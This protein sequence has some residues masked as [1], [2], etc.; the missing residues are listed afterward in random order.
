MKH[1]SKW[2]ELVWWRRNILVSDKYQSTALLNSNKEGV[3]RSNRVA[4][5]LWS[6][7]S[8]FRFLGDKQ[9]SNAQI[10]FRSANLTKNHRKAIEAQLKNRW[11]NKWWNTFASNFTGNYYKALNISCYLIFDGKGYDNYFTQTT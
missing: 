10:H 7:Q 2:S 4:N 1:S 5:V 9:L 11:L 6:D 3:N 8:V